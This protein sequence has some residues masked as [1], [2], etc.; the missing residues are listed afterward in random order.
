VRVR[1]STL[2][3]AARMSAAVRARSK[4]RQLQE[5]EERVRWRLAPRCAEGVRLGAASDTAGAPIARDSSDDEADRQ[6]K[7]VGTTLVLLHHGK[8]RSVITTTHLHIPRASF[9]RSID[10]DETRVP[11]SAAPP[12]HRDE[13]DGRQRAHPPLH[14]HFTLQVKN[15]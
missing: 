7:K 14:S 13:E 5:R 2:L 15:K 3:R 11:P 12:A 10:A 1:S 4:T 9:F 6:R 8:R